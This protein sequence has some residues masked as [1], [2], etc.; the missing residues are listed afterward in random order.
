MFRNYFKV[1][2]RNL[3]KNKGFTAIN[4]IG[5]SVG[6][7]TCLL[8]LL[9]V[10]DELSFDKYNDKANR[11]YRV[12]SDIMFGGNHFVMDVTPEPMA[13]TIKND[14]PEVEADVR[15][16]SYGCFLVRKGSQNLQ[17]EKVIYA[18]STLFSVFTLPMVYGDPKTALVNPNSVVINETTA[19][20][21]FN[22]S[23]VVG[24]SLLVNDEKNMKITGVIKD[25]PS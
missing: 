19:R 2:F 25:M 6:L 24:K 1:A 8:I 12:D 18:D 9:Y 15:F 16:R 13:A 5:L 4:I 17:E 11:I 20:K 7:A 22:T 14:Y 23:D 3:W 21:Y 10:M